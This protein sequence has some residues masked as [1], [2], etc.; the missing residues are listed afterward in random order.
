VREPYLGDSVRHSFR[1]LRT[2]AAISAISVISSVLA[3]AS[4]S[5]AA[6]LGHS[7]PAAASASAAART[8]SYFHQAAPAKLR[9]AASY[10][11]RRG[12]TLSAIAARFHLTW[13]GLYWANRHTLGGDP[14]SIR[15]G[16]RLALRSEAGYKPPVRVAVTDMI[17]HDS[18]SRSRRSAAVY[19][20]YSFSG[21]EALWVSAGGPA[22]VKASAAAIA[23]CESGG[24]ATAYNPSGAS[25]IWQILGTPFPGNPFDPYTNA[26]MAVAKFRA[27]GYSFAPWVCRA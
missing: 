4:V 3:L 5:Q 18:S 9:Q 27:A 6:T 17:R 2:L 15:P 26:R 20:T 25:G 7:T 21:L 1:L 19:G 14:D 8:L 11:V 22:S 10:T 24:R 23:E 13:E 12:D 16:E